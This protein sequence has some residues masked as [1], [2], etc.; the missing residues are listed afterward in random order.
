MI[1][2]RRRESLEGASQPKIPGLKL[3]LLMLIIQ[4]CVW[5]S[6]NVVAI[7]KGVRFP[8]MSDITGYFI[9]AFLAACVGIWISL[10]LS[11]KLRLRHDGYSYFLR[12][13]VLLALFVLLC[14]FSSAK[15]ALYPAV[16]IF[17]LGLAMIVRQPILKLLFWLLSPHFMFRL[18]FSEGFDFIARILHT[19]P[20]ITPVVNAALVVVLALFFSVWAF[21]FLLGFAAMFFDSKIDGRWLNLLKGK[22]AGVLAASL[23]IIAVVV[24]SLEPTYSQEWKPLLR[25]EESFNVDSTKGD[26]VIKG[27]EYLGGTRL[28][29]PGHDTTLH[30]SSTAATFERALSAPTIPWVTINRTVQVARKDSLVAVDLTLRV[31]LYHRPYRFKIYYSNEHGRILDVSSPL[32]LGSSDRSFTLQ[33]SAFP[34]SSL[35]IPISF[36]VPLRDSLRVQEHIEAVFVEV[37]Q[38]VTVESRQ[39]AAVSR[40][41]TFTR[42]SAVW[43]Q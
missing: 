22:T 3:F 25:V 41:S 34:D 24:L 43:L 31:D 29:F 42:D 27:S 17:L 6:D 7:I 16:A 10:H 8:W 30:G 5:L 12:A 14:S 13:F 9:L 1:V 38:P 18:F 26:L 39:P 36:K 20:D 11:P 40:R 33:W 19:Q 35:T 4:V 28:T 32:S 37:P 21:P 15:L 23:F 2:H